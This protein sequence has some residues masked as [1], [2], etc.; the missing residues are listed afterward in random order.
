MKKTI[1]YIIAASHR[2]IYQINIERTQY[3]MQV[4]FA[5]YFLK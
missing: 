2:M 5:W 1:V 3:N 4:D